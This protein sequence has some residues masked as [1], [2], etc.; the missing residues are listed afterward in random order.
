MNC[1][2]YEQLMLDYALGELDSDDAAQCAAHIEVCPACHGAYHSYLGVAGMISAEHDIRPTPEESQ[3]V[4][5]ALGNT[6]PARAPQ[7]LPRGLPAMIWASVLAFVV[8]VATLALQVFGY[9]SLL[10]TA[11]SIGPVPIAAAIVAMVFITS[12]LPIAAMAKRQP[13]NGMTFRR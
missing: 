11:R 2:D 3:A 13:L 1:Q 5:Q 8:I 7:P 10:G 12:F 4:A 6:C 9:V